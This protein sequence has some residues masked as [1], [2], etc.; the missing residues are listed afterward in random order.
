M[1]DGVC[2]AVFVVVGLAKL[3]PL[4]GLSVLFSLMIWSWC[5]CLSQ[6]MAGS[7]DL[8]ANRLRTVRS[9]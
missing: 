1:D 6:K 5:A 3:K 8:A 7:S 2:G 4:G 9:Q